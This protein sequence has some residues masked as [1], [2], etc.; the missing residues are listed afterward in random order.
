MI[1]HGFPISALESV[2][3]GFPAPTGWTGDAAAMENPLTPD[4]P[5]EPEDIEV[6]YDRACDLA[7]AEQHADAAS[8]FRKAATRGH[9]HAWLA[10]GNSLKAMQRPAEAADAYRAAAESGDPDAFLN[11]GL[12]LGDRQDWSGAEAAYRQAETVGDPRAVMALGDLWRWHGDPTAAKDLLRQAAAGGDAH[13]AGYLGTWLR[14]DDPTADVEAL[15]R[16]GAEVDDDA[17]SDLAWIL[18]SRRELDEAERLLRLGVGNGH[19]DSR[20]KLALLLDEDRS[21]PAGAEEILRAGVAAGEL[22]AW[23]NLGSLLCGQGRLLEAESCFRSGA[24]GGDT[25]AA[26]NLRFLRRAYRRQLNRAHRRRARQAAE[27]PPRIAHR[28]T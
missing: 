9:P 15:L 24:A 26:K 8:L 22:F 1:K 13:A 23:N 27:M 25:L 28:N 5:A 11:L 18:R 21:D 16:Q 6:L 14:H 19:D 7:D 17:R 4:V 20:I 12:L 2:R 10:L 3:K